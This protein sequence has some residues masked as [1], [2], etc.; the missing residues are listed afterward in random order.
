MDAS[1]AEVPAFL[2]ISNKLSL[3]SAKKSYFTLND[4]VCRSMLERK[5]LK[6]SMITS[7]AMCLILSGITPAPF[8]CS[9]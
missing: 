4:R 9:F 2:N 5:N 7:G 8:M 6:V 3:N 1:A